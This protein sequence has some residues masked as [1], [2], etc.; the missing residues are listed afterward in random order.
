MHHYTS[1]KY[2]RFHVYHTHITIA[3]YV[4]PMRRTGTLQIG[5]LPLEN[6]RVL[7]QRQFDVQR[8]QLFLCARYEPIANPLDAKVRS[9]HKKGRA[10]LHVGMQRIRPHFP[11]LSVQG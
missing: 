6:A 2:S 10:A 11:I 3:N 5:V 7:A 8:H 4:L 1:R 9:H